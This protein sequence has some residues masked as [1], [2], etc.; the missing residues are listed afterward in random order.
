MNAR[1]GPLLLLLSLAL[2]L[3]PVSAADTEAAALTTYAKKMDSY[4]SDLIDIGKGLTGLDQH[5][6]S[7]LAELVASTHLEITHVQDLVLIESLLQDDGDKRRIKPI[8]SARIKTVTGGID[9][10]IK[11][12]NLSLSGLKSPAV[13]TA[14]TTLKDDL[15]A[16]QAL[17]SSITR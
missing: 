7:K 9:L 2:H 11:R 12:V 8:L 6:A 1:L 14:A 10:S 3:P 17:L 4:G 15:R 16:L 13:V 5:I